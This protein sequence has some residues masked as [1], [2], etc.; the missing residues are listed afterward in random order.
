MARETMC[1]SCGEVTA[2]TL[3]R[4]PNCGRV[5]GPYALLPRSRRMTGS[6]APEGRWSV[7]IGLTEL[8]LAAIATVVAGL[9]IGGLTGLVIALVVVLLVAAFVAFGPGGL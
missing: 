4:C 8:W 2:R 3:G 5:S 6:S 7:G 9:L 1:E